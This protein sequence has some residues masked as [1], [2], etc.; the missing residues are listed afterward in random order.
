MYNLILPITPYM[1]KIILKK[2]IDDNSKILDVGIGN[3]YCINKTA[4]IIK[5]KNLKIQGID[6]DDDYL[7]I[8][9]E[10]IKN[11]KLEKHVRAKKQDLLKMSNDNKYDYILFM[12]S[13]PVIPIKTMKKMVKKSKKLLNPNGKIIFCHNLVDKKSQFVDWFKPRI[14]DIPLLGNIDFGR[15]SSHK[16]FDKFIEDTNLT[17]LTKKH[18]AGFRL[19][20]ALPFL[21]NALDY[22]CEQFLTICE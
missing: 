4:D 15:L 3:G 2:Y 8:C 12:E 17:V 20:E 18:I 11:N 7:E 10:V 16:D 13:Y 22:N 21:P 9:N 1:Y 6:I 5:K 14:K 19:S